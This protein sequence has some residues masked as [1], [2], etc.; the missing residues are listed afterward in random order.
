MRA[1]P[2]SS[3]IVVE[4]AVRALEHRPVEL[5]IVD[6]VLAEGDVLRAGAPGASSATPS[7]PAQAG[8][9]QV[10]G[11]EAPACP[12]YRITRAIEVVVPPP[13]QAADVLLPERL[14]RRGAALRP[15][16]ASGVPLTIPPHEFPCD[17]T[18]QAD[19]QFSLAHPPLGSGS[20]LQPRSRHGCGAASGRQGLKSG[21]ADAISRASS[22]PVAGQELGAVVRELE[23]V[24][25]D[26]R[27][28]EAVHA[29]SVTIAEDPDASPARAATDAAR[30]AA[31][32]ARSSVNGSRHA[33]PAP[34][35]VVSG[36]G[37][38]PYAG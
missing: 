6:L 15:R 16:S 5:A 26:R 7:S 19:A 28:D 2:S 27:P 1:S 3:G 10:R 37:L 4:V 12:R 13:L 35:V 29:R 9:A 14:C 23:G 32:R 38:L 8:Q 24:S 36:A 30:P 34:E 21:P 33:H 25:P 11:A 17:P 22:C 31:C 20:R 18:S